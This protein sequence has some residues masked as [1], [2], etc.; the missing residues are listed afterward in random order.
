MMRMHLTAPPVEQ[1]LNNKFNARDGVE[2]SHM[3]QPAP[4]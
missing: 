1:Y 2:V 3:S 4:E